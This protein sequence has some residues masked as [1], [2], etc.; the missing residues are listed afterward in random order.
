MGMNRRSFIKRAGVGSAIFAFSGYFGGRLYAKERELKR[1]TILHT[2]DTHSRLEPFPD[3]HPKYPSMGGMAKRA[4]LVNKIRSEQKNVLLLDAGDIFQGTPY[5]NFYGGELNFKLMSMLKY[6]A[7]TMGNHDLDNG[8]DGFLKHFDKAKFPFIVSNYDFSDSKIGDKVK[9]Y[10]ILDRDGIKIGIIGA[11]IELEG[12]VDPKNFA[13][14][15]YNDP[16]ESCNV[17]A[18]ELKEEKKCD[19]VIVLSHLGY[20]YK[21]DKVSDVS[22]AANSKNIDIILGGHTHTF[23]DKPD[24][25]KNIVGEDVIVSQAGFGGIRLG[26]LDVYFDKAKNMALAQSEFV[27]IDGSLA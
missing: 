20:K 21:S 22:F 7:A 23:M 3:N 2:N 1:I 25:V 18:A 11:G 15:K 19:L 8:V 24:V 5:F 27:Q 10:S 6:D 17:L 16:V 14:I 4:T 12:L 9:K 13:G 26:R